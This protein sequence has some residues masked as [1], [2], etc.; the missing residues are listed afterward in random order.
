MKPKYRPVKSLRKSAPPKW[1]NHHFVNRLPAL[2]FANTVVYRNRPDRRD[3][4]LTSLA[5]LARWRSF[6]GAGSGASRASLR[7]VLQVRETIDRFF[8]DTAG[9]SAVGA[10]FPRL[11]RLYARHGP[12]AA[13]AKTNQ[14][15]RL[16]HTARSAARAP[17]LA[18]ILQSAVELA[19]SPD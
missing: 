18:G 10:D 2:D 13:L 5:D 14:G 1:Q 17:F 3:D 6:A 7:Q 4:R 16:R 11:I 15:I 12:A 19:F 8:R 9:G